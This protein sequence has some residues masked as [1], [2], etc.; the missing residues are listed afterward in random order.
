MEEKYDFFGDRGHT[1]LYAF[2]TGAFLN[3]FIDN[4]LDITGYF[5]IKQIVYYLKIILDFPLLFCYPLLRKGEAFY[6]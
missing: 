1:L 2:D 4:I 6:E 3:K 5:S